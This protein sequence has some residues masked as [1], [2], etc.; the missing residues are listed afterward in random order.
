M[1]QSLL[2]LFERRVETYRGGSTN[3]RKAMIHYAADR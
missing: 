1:P 2:H 3:R